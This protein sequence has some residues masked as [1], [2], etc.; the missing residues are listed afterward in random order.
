MI[1]G[2]TQLLW[3]VQQN[4]RHHLIPALERV[5]LLF[6]CVHQQQA[7]KFFLI[8]FFFCILVFSLLPPYIIHKGKI[9]LSS[10]CPRNGYPGTRYNCSESGWVNELIFFDW[11]TT[12]FIPAVNHVQ[13]PVL[14]LF[15]GHQSHI[16]TR[17]IRAALDAK[18]ELECLPPHSTTALQP[19]DVVT[20]GKVKTMWKGL[21]REHNASSNLA[22]IDKAKFS[23][24]VS[25]NFLFSRFSFDLRKEMHEY[26]RKMSK[27]ILR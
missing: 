18:I 4:A 17:I 22:P 3:N 11:F 16:S 2:D 19:L 12:Q 14:L 15:D 24:L 9:F 25:L 10:W 26:T 20:L 13:K 7:S 27:R 1:L 21:L 8:I 5:I 6:L 23:L